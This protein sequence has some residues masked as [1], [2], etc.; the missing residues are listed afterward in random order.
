MNRRLFTFSSLALA[1]TAQARTTLPRTLD[2][3]LLQAHWTQA[4]ADGELLLSIRL[5]IRSRDEL[6]VMVSSG[7]R[8]TTRIRAFMTGAGELEL[9]AVPVEFQDYM[10][11]TGETRV[12]TVPVDPSVP[13][14]ITRIGPIPRYLALTAASPIELGEF[15]FK[16][17]PGA[18]ATDSFRAEARVGTDRGHAV[19]SYASTPEAR[20]PA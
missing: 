14:V 17:P 1:V 3:D 9:E 6:S 13:D 16:L 5:S 15:R 19:L 20:P 12:R 2:P 4:V 10:T 7:R 18:S 11:S 8:P